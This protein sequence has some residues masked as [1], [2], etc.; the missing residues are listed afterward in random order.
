MPIYFNRAFVHANQSYQNYTN[1]I[2]N[3]RTKY[4]RWSQLTEKYPA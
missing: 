1:N 3:Q 2:Q 4:F